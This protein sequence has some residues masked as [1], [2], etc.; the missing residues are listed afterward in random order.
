MNEDENI[1]EPGVCPDRA[2][3]AVRR[4]RT[5]LGSV[6]WLAATNHRVGGRGPASS[7]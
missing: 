7:Q 6:L 3:E 4:W 2:E 1:V 5:E